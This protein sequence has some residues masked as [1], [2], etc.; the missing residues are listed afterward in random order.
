MDGQRFD[1]LA[2]TLAAG[3]SRRRA[4]KALAGGG[5]GALLAPTVPAP[6]PARAKGGGGNRAC[7]ERCRALFP[8]GKARGRC[9]SQ[10][11]RGEGPCAQPVCVPF[12]QPCPSGC[13]GG[14]GGRPCP[15]CCADEA[16]T[17]AGGD[18]YAND[19]MCPGFDC[20]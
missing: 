11:A 4:L 13:V 8:P 16:G 6:A 5:L 10:G 7:A 15:A 2:R 20:C 3:I 14:E 18:C 19:P 12:H 9:V 1:E 17:E